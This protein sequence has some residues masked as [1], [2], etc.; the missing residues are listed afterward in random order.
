MKLSSL[1]CAGSV[2]ATLFLTSNAQAAPIIYEVFSVASG[3]IGATTFTTA[4]I[5]LMGTGDTANVVSLTDPS[6]PF[7][8]FAN[9]LSTLTI[10]IGGVGTATI[11]DPPGI[12]S[13]PDLI[14][15]FNPV[16]LVILGRIDHP[17]ALD[18]FTGIG[19]V[20]NTA[21][22]GYDLTSA[23]GPVSGIGGI[24]FDPACGTP[25]HDSCI[26]TSLG[27]LSFTSNT[28]LD[29]GTGTFVATLAPT[30]VPEPATLWLLGS[31]MAALVGRS[32]LRTRRSGEK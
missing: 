24:G 16:P 29:E 2:V 19:G 14:P 6:I 22:A 7:P 4:Q 31:G 28:E 32:R 23:I 15:G 3:K 18:S 30:A 9:P 1:V 5:G 17:P 20:G 8:I 10:T 12:W 25:F 27:F 13:F 21:L 11:A 26:Q